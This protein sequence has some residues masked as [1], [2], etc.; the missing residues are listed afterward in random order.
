MTFWTD[1][2]SNWIFFKH[3]FSYLCIL[4]FIPK[5]IS[6]PLAFFYFLR[7]CLTLGLSLTVKGLLHF[8]AYCWA[9]NLLHSQVPIYDYILTNTRSPS[10]YGFF[11]ITLY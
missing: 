11:S 7:S 2:Q 8:W 5:I 4:T 9:F 1:S 10:S 6:K 3:Y